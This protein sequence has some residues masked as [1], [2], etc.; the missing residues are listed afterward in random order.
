[1][2]AFYN[3]AG[4][5]HLVADVVGYYDDDRST[6]VGRFLPAAPTRLYDSR[7]AGGPLGPGG[8]VVL[9]PVGPA[10]MSALVLNVTATEPTDSSFLAVFPAPGAWT[11]ASN[12]NVV[13]GQTVPN[14]V[15]ATLGPGGQFA[16]LNNAGSTQVVV[17]VFGGFTGATFG[18]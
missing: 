13:P 3:N 16:V 11:G 4:S 12:L 1:V 18:T 5:T 10:G 15:V 8:T 9:G 17:D 2:V 14:G 6:G 7:V